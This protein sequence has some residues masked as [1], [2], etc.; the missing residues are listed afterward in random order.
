MQGRVAPTQSALARLQAEHA[1]AQQKLRDIEARSR[2]AVTPKLKARIEEMRANFPADAEMFDAMLA[3]AEAAQTAVAE[4]N[5]RIAAIEERAVRSEQ[6]A[7][8]SDMHPGWQRTVQSPEFGN[9]MKALHPRERTLMEQLGASIKAEDAGYV[10]T[11]FKSDVTFQ[12][13]AF[14]VWFNALEQATRDQVSTLRSQD[15]MQ[16]IGMFERDAAAAWQDARAHP[17]ATPTG[18]A[19]PASATAV[20]TPLATPTPIPDPD[21]SRRST[22]PATMMPAGQPISDKKRDFIRASEF[23]E[24]QLAA[25]ASAR[26]H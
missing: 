20:S 8:L 9:W 2:T 19:P 25:R 26:R 10:L 14:A 16:V 5:A 22:A 23:F 4:S 7:I 1:Q 11:K 15:P 21:P 12:N 17:S 18:S 24:S 6:M 3:G 13:P